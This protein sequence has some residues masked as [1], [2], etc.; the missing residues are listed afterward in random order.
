MTSRTF[1]KLAKN[2]LCLINRQLSNFIKYVPYRCYMVIYVI[3]K[4]CNAKFYMY[5]THYIDIYNI[6]TAVCK[7][8]LDFERLLFS[9]LA[10][11]DS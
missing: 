6:F 4:I 8:D 11:N 10:K 1:S 7:A 5:F 9:K 3:L 2:D